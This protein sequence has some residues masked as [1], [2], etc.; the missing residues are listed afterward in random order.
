MG[1][2]DRWR[3]DLEAWALPQEL[4]DGVDRSP[5]GWPAQLFQRM[6][7]FE[8]PTSPT[9]ERTAEPAGPG[10]SVL[11]VGAGTGRIGLALA[12]RGHPVTFVER[13]E[14]M[15]EGLRHDA[16]TLGVDPVVVVGSWP[17]VDVEP[18]DVVVCANV[19]YDVQD[20]GPFVSGLHR[21]AR[22]AVVV[23]A[24]PGHPWSHLT[25]Y[26]RVMHGL[27]RPR[28][29]VVEDLGAVIAETVGAAP[30]IERWPAPAGLRFADMQELVDLMAMRLLVPGDR[31]SELMDL[32]TP[33]VVEDDGWLVLGRTEREMCTVTWRT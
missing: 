22:R 16:A 21:A 10:G 28:G 33:D 30:S 13:N 25:P 6:R 2:A 9:I 15:L 1:A 5:Y 24:T 18:H 8:T 14:R 20:I 31:W 27:E 3:T 23:E 19:V 26:Y 4:L 12:G 11:D 17:D 29:P 32:L 7:R